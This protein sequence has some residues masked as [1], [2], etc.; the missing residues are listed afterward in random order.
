MFGKLVNKN[1]KMKEM[2]LPKANLYEYE[3]ANLDKEGFR[4]IEKGVLLVNIV[5]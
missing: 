1:R 2:F 5:F 3:K 4:F